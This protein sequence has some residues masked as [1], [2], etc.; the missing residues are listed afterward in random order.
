[1][2]DPNG[3][4]QNENTESR[5]YDSRADAAA[6]VEEKG[7]PGNPSLRKILKHAPNNGESFLIASKDNG[8]I[9]SASPPSP[10]KGSWPVNGERR[11][12]LLFSLNRFVPMRGGK[13]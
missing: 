8:K 11:N 5:L 2:K 9:F 3:H 10:T 12:F 13:K 1:V 6:V 4:V 7:P